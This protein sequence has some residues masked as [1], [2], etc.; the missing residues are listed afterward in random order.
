MSTIQ[1]SKI[2]NCLWFDNQAEQAAAYYTS[3]FKHSKLGKTA[4]YGKEGHD[5]HKKPAGSVM[6]A[7]FWIEGQRFIALNGGPEFKFNESVSFVINCET[8]KEIDEY[9]E[10]LAQ[11]GDKKSQ[12]CGW[13]KDKFGLSWQVV[14]TILSDLFTSDDREKTERV[15][16][17]MMQMKKLDIAQLKQA[18]D[19]KEAVS[20]KRKL[21]EPV[22]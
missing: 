3:I 4:R 15:M 2:S 10:K 7:E 19:G 9:W 22:H 6:T 5:I 17:A 1:N 18:F 20:E 21:S 16:K 8:Q 14:P 12:Q 13:V 11:G